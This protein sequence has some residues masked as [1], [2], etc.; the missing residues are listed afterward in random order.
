MIYVIQIL[1]FIGYTIGLYN[2]KPDA[3]FGIHLVFAFAGVYWTFYLLIE[4][5]WRVR[6]TG[7]RLL[8]FLRLCR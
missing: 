6:Q 5:P 2:Y 7:L 4:A 3:N 8:R 1:L